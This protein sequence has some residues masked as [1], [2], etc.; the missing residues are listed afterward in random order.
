MDDTLGCIMFGLGQKVLSRLAWFRPNLISQETLAIEKIEILGAVLELPAR[1]NP[2]QKW[3]M[4]KLPVLFSW[5][6]SKTAPIIL[7]FSK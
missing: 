6:S 2:A 3:A 7:I 4:A 1:Q 5:Y